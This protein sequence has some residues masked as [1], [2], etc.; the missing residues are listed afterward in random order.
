MPLRPINAVAV[1]CGSNFGGSEAYAEGARQLGTTLA[2]ENITLVYGGTTKGLM[3]IVADAV[4]GHGGSAHGVITERLHARGHSHA[5][6]TRSERVVSLR[7]RKERMTELADAFIAMPGGIGTME[8]MMEVWTMNQLSEIDK[9]VGLL[10]I[11][12]FFAPFLKFI[13][14]MVETKFLP[15]A[16]R[17]SI[18]VDP[19]AGPLLDKLR[20]FERT[21]VPKWL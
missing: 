14:H 3:G 18:S 10:D 11:D 5:G 9:P 4:L 15:P 13:D 17:H 1:F 19:N 12:G 2:R 16:H 6:L 21:D 7:N 20:H 8:E